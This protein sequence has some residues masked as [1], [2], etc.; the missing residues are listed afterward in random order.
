M[1]LNDSG[2]QKLASFFYVK[3]RENE[4]IR[5]FYFQLSFFYD[6]G[7]WLGLFCYRAL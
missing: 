7:F 4:Q 6:G 3:A 5:I 2:V 1:H